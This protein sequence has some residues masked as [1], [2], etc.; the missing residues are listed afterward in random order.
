MKKILL[1]LTAMVFLI[2]M[3]CA[4][5]SWPWSWSS[6]AP[7]GAEYTYAVETFLAQLTQ[8]VGQTPAV[9]QTLA[10]QASATNAAA[11]LPGQTYQPTITLGPSLT[12]LPSITP[13]PP[14]LTPRPP[15]AVPAAPC[16]QAQLIK[17]INY[18]DGAQVLPG[19]QFTKVWRL[20]NTG[21]CTWTPDYSVV[22]VDGDYM[23]V[24]QEFS[25]DDDVPPGGVVDVAVGLAAPGGSG[26]YRSYWKLEDG[27]GHRFGVS[28]NGNKAFW[29]DIE[30]VWSDY[31]FAY[32]FSNNMCEASWN[33]SAGDLPCPGNPDSNDGSVV[34]L[35]HPVFETGKH[36]NE[37]ALWTRPETT[38]DG[39]IRGI[40]PSYKVHTNDHFMANV[41][42]LQD[43]QGCSLKFILQYKKGNATY[44][45]GE[46]L[47]NYD[48]NMTRIDLDLNS[49]AGNS[50]QFILKVVNLGK[51]YRANAFWFVPSIR[52]VN[53]TATPKP[54]STTVPVVPTSTPTPTSTSGPVDRPTPTS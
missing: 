1:T 17:D 36:E 44:E 51:P 5:L 50:V 31:D 15:T 8:N 42:C 10:A 2:T 46:W 23:G 20:R 9:L 48:G 18:P 11:G 29:V 12:P 6:P 43:S 39:W 32:D 49:L 22:F 41:G 27:N 30:V 19:A 3:A 53:S 38:H 40:Y 14:S 16:R 34:Y 13:P 28:G 26:D 45:L 21:S 54:T 33:S 25:F 7:Q 37:P 35:T 4:T 47:E 52:R 24:D